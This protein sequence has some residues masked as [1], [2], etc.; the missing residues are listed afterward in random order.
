MSRL[1]RALWLCAAF[2]AGCADSPAGPGTD[3][4]SG[5]ADMALVADGSALDASNDD[6]GI[7]MDA[8]VG[9]TRCTNGLDDDG[10]GLVDALDPECTG[11]ADNDEGTFG[12]G[13]PGDNRDPMWQDCFFD[14]NSGAGDDGCRYRTGC[15]TGE[16]PQ[17]DPDCTLSADYV[18]FCEPGT[19]NGCDCFGC[20]AVDTG[21]GTTVNI[22]LGGSCS[23]ANI[24]DTTACPRC[25]PTTQCDNPCGR[26][27]LCPGRTV[28]DLPPDCAPDG[29][30]PYACDNGEQICSATATCPSGYS[31]EL[32]CCLLNL[33]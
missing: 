15:L 1:A 19:P 9:A 22:I 11:S 28:A 6:T 21:S 5:A 27:E 4:G 14:G 26:C 3:A 24:D 23:E 7:A 33:F 25:M 13:I 17:S 18:E 29:G 31:C 2:L 30:Q 8:Q 32:G 16:L 20:C 12:T 10:D